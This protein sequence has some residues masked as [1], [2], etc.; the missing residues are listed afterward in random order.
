MFS[1]SEDA[2]LVTNESEE[3]NSKQFYP[4]RKYIY[5]DLKTTSLLSTG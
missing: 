5:V 4:R 1:N 2:L 3:R